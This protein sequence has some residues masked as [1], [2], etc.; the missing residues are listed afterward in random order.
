M[1]S[2]TKK[3]TK[4]EKNPATEGDESAASPKP[5]ERKAPEV[6]QCC[7]KTARVVAGCHD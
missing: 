2:L 7:A 6:A 3:K 1:K 5:E 4:N